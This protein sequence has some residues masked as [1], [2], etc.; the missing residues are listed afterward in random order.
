MISLRKR[1]K[2]GFT[3]VVAIAMLGLL[4][5]MGIFLMQSSSAEYSQTSL[6]LYRTMGR[7]LAEAAAEEAAVYIE[8][9]L[10]DKSQSGFEQLLKKAGESGPAR[11]DKPGTGGKWPTGLSPDFL[12]GVMD[13]S[14]KLSESK[15][16]LTHIPRAGFN[17]DSVT[18]TIEDI[19]PIPQGPLDKDYCYTNNTEESNYY[20]P[21]DRYANNKFYPFDTQYSKDWYGTLHIVVKVSLK[22]QPSMKINYSLSKD[23]KLV[24]VGPI[25]RNYTYYSVVGVYVSDYSSDAAFQADMKNALNRGGGLVNEKGRL[26]LWNQPFLSRVFLHGPAIINLENPNIG[27]DF[28]ND[29]HGVY[30]Y[31][32]QEGKEDCGMGPSMAYQY[33]DTFYGFSYF[34]PENRCLYPKRSFKQIWGSEDNIPTKNDSD[35][36]SSIS[37]STVN[38]ATV[39]G[40][41]YQHKDRGIFERLKSF[42]DNNV[43]DKYL[44]GT[45]QNQIFLPAGPFCRTPWRYVSKSGS[46]STG[47]R[48]LPNSKLNQTNNQEVYE[49]PKTDPEIRL[50]HRWNPS[51]EKLSESYKIC[52]SVIPFVVR[53]IGWDDDDRQAQLKEF[54]LSYHNDKGSETFLGKLAESFGNIFSPLWNFVT[55][56]FDAIGTTL[57]SAYNKYLK[58]PEKVPETEEE[59]VFNNLFPTNFKF[60]LMS[61]VTKRF[62]DENEIPTDEKGNWILNGIYA[63]DSLTITQPVCYV[64]TGTIIV[65][66]NTPVE[67]LGDVVAYREKPGD[68][69]QGHLNIIYHPVDKALR[70]NGPGGINDLE[71]RLLTI[72]G[73]GITIEASVYSYLG[74]RSIG[75][76]NITKEE[77]VSDYYMSPKLPTDLWINPNTNKADYMNGIMEKANCIFGNYINYYMFSSKQED[78]L[79]VIHNFD[80]PYF[81]IKDDENKVRLV[82][83][84]LDEE[85]TKAGGFSD[86]ALEYEKMCHE[87]FMSPKIQHIGIGK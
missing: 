17:I 64:G 71:N 35:Y 52:S 67:I 16:L 75:D 72:R 26:I 73:S 59:K 83:D 61:V 25:A 76:C 69:P 8:E 33:S 36:L 58:K 3:Y 21:T 18:A 37:F 11:I 57:A 22:K 31:L 41:Y 23:L 55:S 66:K 53:N 48:Y 20:T 79:W 15:M 74:V 70:D 82:Q 12:D 46:S 84:Y 43:S 45:N 2:S 81:F 19:R 30:G 62:K 14:S 9:Q 34:E 56:P 80:D 51:D 85:N 47:F 78:D 1:N 87:F 13:L 77:L 60:N 38:D 24:N 39:I 42:F 65:G 32:P 7:Q 44:V 27:K 49:F 10:K 6:S 28:Q 63:L 86:A 54:S 40:G 29:P 4:A 50:E 5:F 68:P